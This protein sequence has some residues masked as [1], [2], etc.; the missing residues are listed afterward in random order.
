MLPEVRFVQAL[1]VTLFLEAGVLLVFW[2][3]NAF[4]IKPSWKPREWLAAAIIP[5]TLTLPY[6][7]FVL[8]PFVNSAYYILFGEVLVT[9]A[10]TLLLSYLLRL[11]LRNALVLSVAANTVSYSVGL[12]VPLF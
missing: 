12:L 5:S 6:L 2:K 11:K 9:L 10:E 7:W 8:P 4:R 3:L 1:A